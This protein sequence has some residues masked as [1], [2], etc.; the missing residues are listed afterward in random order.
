MD[1]YTHYFPSAAVNTACWDTSVSFDPQMPMGGNVGT[2]L[3]APGSAPVPPGVIYD[4]DGSLHLS[5]DAGDAK[6]VTCE[7]Y[8]KEYPLTRDE[9]GLWAAH[10]V[11]GRVG[12]CPLLFRVDGSE[13]INPLAPI[14]FGGSKPIN[15]ADIPN[16]NGKFYALEDVPHGTVAQ[17]YYYS[18]STDTWKS[19]LVYLPPQ[20][21]TEPER[22][23]P[24]LYLQHGHG[25]NEQ[26]WVH[27]GR[28]NFILDNLIASGKAQPMIIV[29]NNGMVQRVQDGHRVL[30]FVAIEKLL[31]EDCIQY[32]DRT[33]RTL[34][35]KDHRAMAG[36]SMGSMQTSYV[37]LRHS[38]VFAYAGVFSGFVS[39][40]GDT[41]KNVPDHLALLDNREEFCKAF[42]VFFRATG[43]DDALVLPS[44]ENDN[45]MFADKGLAPE[46]CP[47]HIIR[48]YEGEHE[49]NVW[50]QCLRDFAQLIF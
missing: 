18:A 7:I 4:E 25:E 45:K 46:V 20:Y 12:F 9:S 38:D 48:R 14:G 50:R 37:T 1:N 28:A 2:R 15:Y 22:R 31:V 33:F 5:F 47:S 32:I 23:F 49:W 3:G 41:W 36:L 43:N 10:V 24:V 27:Q 34:T 16:P 30:D 42:K 6:S 44:F 26:C 40:L 39:A 8:R 29:M 17:C 11:C 21:M 35:D 19:C 13:V